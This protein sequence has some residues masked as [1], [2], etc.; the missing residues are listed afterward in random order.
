LSSVRKRL[1]WSAGAAF[2]PQ[3]AQFIGFIVLAR[4]LTP[5]DFG[6]VVI[7][8]T[9]LEF[10]TLLQNSGVSSYIV[11]ARSPDQRQI[12]TA[13]WLNLILSILVGFIV[14]LST[15]LIAGV[16][17]SPAAVPLIQL[18]AL[19]CML[20]IGATHLGL[21][22]RRYRF[23]A[24][25]VSDTAAMTISQIGAIALAVFGMGPLSI[26]LG[27]L[28]G[29]VLQLALYATFSKWLPS[30][31]IDRETVKDVWRYGRHV[32]GFNVVNYWS[33]NL[34]NLIIAR[35]AGVEVLGFYSRAYTLMLLPVTLVSG[36]IG[37]VLQPTLARQQHNLALAM[38]TWTEYTLLSL[39]IGLPIA[40]LLISASGV[41]TVALLG[42]QWGS[43]AQFLQILA[44]SIA[45][46]LAIRPLGFAFLA[47]G[48]TRALLMIGLLA[49]AV[50]ACMM[51]VGNALLGATGVALGFTTAYFIHLGIYLSYAKIRWQLRLSPLIWP[52]VRLLIA[53]AVAALSAELVQRYISD[54]QIHGRLAVIVLVSTATYSLAVWLL[55]PDV[56]RR[57]LELLGRK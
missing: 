38:V 23:D 5:A 37:K 44:L 24:V 27:R 41:I 43:A 52:A 33:R 56:L 11:H 7:A 14:L 26:V 50:T 51:L 20:N 45:P 21:L 30:W 6:L 25:A 29:Q 18:S 16:F 31:T 47:L 46:Q 39:L 53:G 10:S 8:M 28:G 34:D 57:A 15:D 48:R 22:Q 54:V 49:T 9:V 19:G 12:S 55:A 4:L 32:L 35:S 40:A 36:S 42:E 17:N 13:F 1:A 2:G 3:L